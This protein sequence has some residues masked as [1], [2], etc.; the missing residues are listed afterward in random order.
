MKVTSGG[1]V[2]TVSVP[3]VVGPELTDRE[4]SGTST[5][6]AGVDPAARPTS[7]STTAA[8]PAIHR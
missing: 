1:G 8:P 6:P 3:P 5:A 2:T 7:E 4:K